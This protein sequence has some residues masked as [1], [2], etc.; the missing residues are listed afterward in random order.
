MNIKAFL[1]AACCV[2][3]FAGNAAASTPVSNS[4]ELRIQGF[5]P[6]I[7]RASV[8]ATLATPQRGLVQLGSLREFCNNASG[9]Q[10]WIDYSPQL[11]GSILMVDG[12]PV[13]LAGGGS[14]LIGQSSHAASQTRALAL[15]LQGLRQQGSIS[16]RMVP[17]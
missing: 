5:V 2:A 11:S 13:R 16:F 9:Y 6:V 4:F 10:I 1:V 7:C 17:L 8:D 15:Q 3:L 12:R 14:V